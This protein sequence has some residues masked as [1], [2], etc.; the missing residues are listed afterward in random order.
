MD[1]FTINILCIILLSVFSLIYIPDLAFVHSTPTS[2]SGSD[3][4]GGNITLSP[5]DQNTGGSDIGGGNITLSPGDQNT[6]E[7]TNEG[8]PSPFEEIAN[9]IKSFFNLK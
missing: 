1:L 4:G 8:S 7:M 2:Y 3:I 9:A 5:G 6:G